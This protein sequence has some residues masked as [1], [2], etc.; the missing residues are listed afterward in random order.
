MTVALTGVVFTVNVAVVA[1]AA[2]VTEAGR[3]AADDVEL[4]AMLAPPV[5]A[6]PLKVTVPD[7]E[8]PPIT[9][10][11]LRARLWST[12][13]L[14][15]SVAV[16]EVLPWVA[17]IVAVTRADTGVVL[18]ENVAVVEPLETVTLAG[19]DALELLDDSTTWVPIGP[20]GPLRV[21]VPVDELPPITDVGV[22]VTELN[23]AAA[24][25]SVACRRVET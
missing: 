18:T 3:V 8:S 23:V 12:A 9:L 20:A 21:T 4:R 17:V 16:L 6:G 15:V 22:N 19:A 14:I 7:E 10:V 13:G 25:V 1:P 24:I 11:G 5:G 2:T